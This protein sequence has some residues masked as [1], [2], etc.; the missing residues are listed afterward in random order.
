VSIQTIIAVVAAVGV[1]TFAV[2]GV[3]RFV[4]SMQRGGEQDQQMIA[5]YVAN[6]N[7]QTT[8]VVRG[9]NRAEL[10]KILSGFLPAYDLPVD[11]TVKI[12]EESA[13]KFT[14]TF[15]NDIQP[16]FLYFLVNYLQ[17][18]KEVDPKNRSIAVVARVVLTSA[19]GAPNDALVG[20]NA[21]IYVPANDTDYDLVYIRIEQGQA[22]KISFTDLVW[23]PV[24][25][26]RIPNSIVGL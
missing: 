15:P 24:D 11:S 7:N 25:K 19:F 8:L 12:K 22:Y 17:Y 18:P 14:I 21:M 23:Q 4:V 16:K 10:D 6:P 13:D 5:A 3:A 1:A 20:K 2:F 9:W 26:M